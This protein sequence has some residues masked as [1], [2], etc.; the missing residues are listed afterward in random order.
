MK[1]RKHFHLLLLVIFGV[2][3]SGCASTI[4]LSS[5]NKARIRHVSVSEEIKLPEK[6]TYYGW[7]SPLTGTAFI[8]DS[9]S[10]LTASLLSEK[11]NT[12]DWSITAY[13]NKHHVTPDL[14]LRREF[15][16]QLKSNAHFGKPVVREAADAHFVLTIK[17]WG[18]GQKNTFSKSYKPIL[19]VH[20]RLI[21]NNGKTIW[22]D[23]QAI[24]NTSSK[25][26][27][28][29]YKEYFKDPENMRKAF[30]SASELIVAEMMKTL[31]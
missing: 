6:A 8:G 10:Q 30:S 18:I 19:R 14:I 20:A 31:G 9:G 21:D 28:T 5:D 25:T 24:R 4:P 13:A 11:L 1:S 22:E 23:Y 12:K 3:L 27:G 16:R 7:D 29:G 15:I 17:G 26:W 2:M